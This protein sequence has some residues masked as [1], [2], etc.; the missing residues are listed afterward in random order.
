MG[1]E[2]GVFGNCQPKLLFTNLWNAG[3]L[4][5]IGECGCPAGT[6]THVS[7]RVC[8]RVK[9]VF[10]KRPATPG[11]AAMLGLDSCLTFRPLSNKKKGRRIHLAASC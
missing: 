8:T 4:Q 5:V 1:H 3:E 2:E 7:L 9:G 10:N 6:L 11:N